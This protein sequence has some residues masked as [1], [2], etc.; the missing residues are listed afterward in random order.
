MLIDGRFEGTIAYLAGLQSLPEMFAWSFAMMVQY[1]AERGMKVHY[2][3]AGV[4]YHAMARNDLADRMKGD[5]L[6]QLDTDHAFEPDLCIRLLDRMERLGLDVM[7][8]L[9]LFKNPP[10]SPVLYADQGRGF[11]ALRDWDAEGVFRID[12]AGAGCLLVR[13]EVFAR[14]R[15]ELAEAPFSPKDGLSEDLSFFKRLQVLDIPV[16]CDNRIEC[17]HTRIVPVTLENYPMEVR[18]PTGAIA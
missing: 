15:K 7:V 10:H 12:A 17:P 13:R 11:E 3:R 8:G 6:L 16:F 1:N 14:I 2:D 5:W 9:Y 18:R 4:S